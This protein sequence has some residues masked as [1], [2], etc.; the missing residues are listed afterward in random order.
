VGTQQ[1]AIISRQNRVEHEALVHDSGKRPEWSLAPGID[2]LRTGPFGERTHTCHRIVHVRDMGKDSGVIGTR[3]DSDDA[4]S[5]GRNEDL[6]IEKLGYSP[7]LSKSSEARRCEHDGVD[8]ALGNA[9][10]AG[11]DVPAY[12]SDV[13]VWAPIKQEGATAWAAC[14][15]RRAVWQ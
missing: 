13:E 3:F 14:P 15:H 12:W 1:R 9:A 8:G 11:I 10:Q 5:D 7:H 4:L 6:R 2:A